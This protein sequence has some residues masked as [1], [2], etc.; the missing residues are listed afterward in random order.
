MGYVGTPEN[1]N[2][3]LAPSSALTAFV[4]NATPISTKKGWR[5]FGDGEY[6]VV[7]LVLLRL[8]CQGHTGRCA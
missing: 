2:R 4:D 3:Y 1:N 5:P 7:L 6:N 8:Q